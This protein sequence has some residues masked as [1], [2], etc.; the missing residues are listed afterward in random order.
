MTTTGKKRRTQAE[1]SAETREKILQAT[2]DILFERGHARLTTAL[3]DERAGVSSGARVHHFP[4]KIDLVVAATEQT[5]ARAKD[6][7]RQRA[8]TARSSANP[9]REYA[10]DCASV[11]FDW[12]FV[13]ALEV[14]VTARTD[15]ELMAR[16]APVLDDFHREMKTTWTRSLVEAGYDAAVADAELTLTLN[17]IR[18]MAVNRIWQRNDAT[19]IAI[20]DRWCVER[21]GHI[22]HRA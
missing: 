17:L 19:Y 8:E 1:R 5:Y 14:V 2:I 18:G 13:A 15:D 22:R 10:S 6:I 12:P 9:L 11:Y 4:S 3:V 20:L 16:L 7:G 21:A